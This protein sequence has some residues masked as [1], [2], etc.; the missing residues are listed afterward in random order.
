M[1]ELTQR[2]TAQAKFCEWQSKAKG[3]VLFVDPNHVVVV[4]AQGN[5]VALM[6]KSGSYLVRETM[7]TAERWKRIRTSGLTPNGMLFSQSFRPLESRTDIKQVPQRC[8]RGVGADGDERSRGADFLAAN[9]RREP[10]LIF[11]AGY[12]K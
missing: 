9:S 4:K 6:H 10:S 11:P 12:R 2:V 7:A 1:I 8:L 3:R 5:Y